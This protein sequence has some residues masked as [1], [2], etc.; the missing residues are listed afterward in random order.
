MLMNEHSA[1]AAVSGIA[2]AHLREARFE[3]HARIAALETAQ[4]LNS[5]GYDDWSRLW[6]ANPAYRELN[7]SSPIGW[8]LETDRNEIVGTLGNIPLSYVFDG[9]VLRVAT[10]RGW[11][12]EAR[13]R[14]FA[15]LLMDRFFNQ[16]GVDLFLNTTVSALSADAFDVFGAVRVPDGDWSKAA[17]RIAAHR[18]FAEGA[19]RLKRAPFA[20]MASYPAG[21]ALYIKDMFT[22]RRFPATPN[23]HVEEAGAFDSRFDVFWESLECA[24]S[25]LLGVRTSEVLDWHFGGSLAEGKLRI[26]TVSRRGALRAYAILQR[27][28]EPKSG[29][30]RLRLVDFQALECER[31]YGIA[32][33]RAALDACRRD[34]VDVLENIGCNV[35][36]TSFFDE[37]APYRRNLST[38]S[39]SYTTADPALAEALRDPAAW[40][41]SSFDGDA[42]L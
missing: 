25:G 12:V 42:S 40:G 15:L 8:V 26:F 27:R 20:A 4:G 34:R 2:T 19:L 11:A 31:E 23:F 37:F 18:R 9:R 38:W 39:Y 1:T 3:D 16:S 6:L 36:R 14:S 41:P 21:S 29:L 13:Y 7:G 32:M 5:R 22:A 35:Q 28:D 30:T 17:Y 33:M 24:S 10:G